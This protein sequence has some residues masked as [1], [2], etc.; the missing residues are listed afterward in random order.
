MTLEKLRD[1][2]DIIA[3]DVIEEYNDS[4]FC[5]RFGYIWECV[6]GTKEAVYPFRALEAFQCIPA[7]DIC[8]LNE[9]LE[10][11]DHPTDFFHR[12]QSIVLEWLV[13]QV[14]HKVDKLTKE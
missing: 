5:D 4:S 8:D 9:E 2:V 3:E 14:Q 7:S 11:N 1:L 6:H 10:T 13:D 12:I